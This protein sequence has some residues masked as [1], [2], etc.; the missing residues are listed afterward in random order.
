MKKKNFTIKLSQEN[1][2]IYT[3]FKAVCILKGCYVQ[4]EL[5]VAM[6]EYINNKLNK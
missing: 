6:Q 3:K 5:G 4:D 1:K 2:H